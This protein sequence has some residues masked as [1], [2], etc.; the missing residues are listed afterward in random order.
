MAG[1]VL[2]FMAMRKQQ[3]DAEELAKKQGLNNSGR[4]AL[5]IY[6]SMASAIS[7][8]SKAATQTGWLE[9]GETIQY[10]EDKDKVE[11]R[12]DGKVTEHDLSSYDFL[13]INTIGLETYLTIYGANDDG[14]S[15]EW[16]I[17]IAR[18]LMGI[19]GNNYS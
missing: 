10:N 12:K 1:G 6:R 7:A 14:S 19:Y 9:N 8:L 16:G 13:S 4:F 3:E 5:F 18:C 17:A 15:N 2:L 11:I